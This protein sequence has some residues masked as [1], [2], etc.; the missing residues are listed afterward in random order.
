MAK[1]KVPKKAIEETAAT[2]PET[3]SREIVAAQSNGG[4]SATNGATK[5]VRR[6][7]AAKPKIVKSDSRATLVPINL[8]EEIRR[9]AYLK[10][11]R[12]GFVPGHE[13]DDWFAA[14][15]EV[16]QRYHQHSA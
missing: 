2:T 8:E 12:R 6:K 13:A 3:A 5:A 15:H 4:G 14:E 7:T 11:E 1:P 10:A 9:L 16:R